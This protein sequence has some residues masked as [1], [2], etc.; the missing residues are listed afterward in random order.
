MAYSLR[1]G[2]QK[3]IKKG[4]ITERSIKYWNIITETQ[5][6]FNIRMAY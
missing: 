5:Q 1:K 3:N 4:T 6:R 2:Q